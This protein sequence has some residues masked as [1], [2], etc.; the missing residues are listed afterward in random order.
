MRN[1]FD[2]DGFLMRAMSDLMS[3]VILNV[4]TLICSIPIVTAGASISAMH[5]VLYQ[6]ADDGEGKIAATFLREFKNNLKNGTLIW[7]VFLICIGIGGIEYTIFREAEGIGRVVLVA[8]Y[9]GAFILMFLYVW[10][11]PLTA[12]FVY[13]TGNAFR[14]AIYLAATHLPR[15]ILMVLIMVVLSFVLTQDM[16]LLPL[17]FLLGISFP[18]YLC[19]LVYYPVMKKMIEK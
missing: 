18:S 7:L 4:L 11:F 15:T 1:L 9:G 14:N 13:S 5:Y 6:M 12:K 19:T 2:P 16:R 8:L 10:V 17:A 3:L